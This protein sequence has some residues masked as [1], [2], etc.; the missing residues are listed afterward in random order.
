MVDDELVIQVNRRACAHL[1]D[2]EG[3][4]LADRVVGSSAR[5]FS[6]RSCAV[7][8]ESTRSLIGAHAS[9][10]RLAKVPDLDL[11]R[12]AQINAAVALGTDLEVDQELDVAVVLVCGEIDTLAIVDDH[13][14]FDAPVFL[15]FLRA[16]GEGFCFLFGA[17]R[18]EFAR[19]H[20]RQPM[21]AREVLAVKQGRE[22]LG[23]RF[24]LFRS[25]R[26]GG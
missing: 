23:K 11:G 7:V 5:I 21:P 12:P 3:V 20:R 8:P 14:V 19:I 22:A 13:A 9:I 25:L 10:A 26:P 4:P 16:R 17:H 6:R 2:P 15:H 1:D 24:I 18:L